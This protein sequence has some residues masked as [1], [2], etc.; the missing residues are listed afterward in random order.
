MCLK[1]W[2]KLPRTWTCFPNKSEEITEKIHLFKMYPPPFLQSCWF[3]IHWSF[4]QMFSLNS[5]TKIFVITVK[6]LEP[7]ISCVRDQDATTEP[8]RQT[9]EAGSLNSVPFMLQWFIR[10]PEFAEFTEFNESSAAFRKKLQCY[11]QSFNI[12]CNSKQTVCL[13]P[14]CLRVCAS[15]AKLIW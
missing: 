13:I 14:I 2:I 6:G 10:F 8:A 1:W 4:S 11:F 9:W 3:P 7:A 15:L 5:V 12:S